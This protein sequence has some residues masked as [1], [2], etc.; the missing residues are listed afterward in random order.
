[1]KRR[2]FLGATAA[3]AALVMTQGKARAAQSA[4]VTQLAAR[5]PA[6]FVPFTAPG[7]VVRVKKPGSLMPNQI[8]PKPEAA[9]EMLERVMTELTGKRSL[10]DAMKL[11]VHPQ[12]KVC[13][14]VNGIALRNMATNKEFVMPLLDAIIASGVPAAS[15][16]VLEQYPSFLAGTRI[17]ASNVPRGVKVA[18]HGNSDA[19]MDFRMIPGTGVQTKFVRVL[20]ESTALINV[21]L[22][23]DHSIAGYT[24]ALKNMTHGMTINPQD[25]H[26][27]HAAPQIALMAAQ[28]VLTS[29]M[30]LHLSD[31]YK[32]ICQGG[33]LDKMPQYRLPY[34]AV[35]ASTDPVA[36]DTIGWEIVDELRKKKRLPTLSAIGRTPSYIAAA[37]GLG[38]GVADRSRIQ[39]HDVA[40]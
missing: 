8:Y 31:V 24:G 28:D 26:L 21:S 35:M 32:V 20:T 23:K 7:R 40:I 30:R 33:P 39:L 6:G 1:M 11:F 38:L 15:I 17:N 37:G 4:P 16:T 29:R 9:K 27:H 19:T 14:K 2:E 3:G 25:F 36:L 5:P 34:E 12:D 13:V 18:I 10:V 22:V